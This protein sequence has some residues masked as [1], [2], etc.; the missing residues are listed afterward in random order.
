MGRTPVWGRWRGES[1][2][3]R[4]QVH[5]Q[6]RREG[7]DAPREDVLQVR[8]NAPPVEGKANKRVLDVLAQAFG[9]PLSRVRL[10]HGARSR[11]KL[12]RIERPERIP[13]HLE[14]ALQSLRQVDQTRKAV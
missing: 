6:S 12:I 11:R 13:E 5:T 9:V 7:L 14:S 10:V 3:L 8:V 1:L 2:E 4:V